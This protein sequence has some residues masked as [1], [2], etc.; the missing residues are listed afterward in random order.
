MGLNHPP[1]SCKHRSSYHNEGPG[2]SRP[3]AGPR[4]IILSWMSNCVGIMYE[5]DG[6]ISLWAEPEWSWRDGLGMVLVLERRSLP[7]ERSHNKTGNFFLWQGDVFHVICINMPL[8]RLVYC[9]C[10]FC[11]SCE[12][13][14]TELVFSLIPLEEPGE[15]GSPHGR[16]H[17]ERFQHQGHSSYCPLNPWRKIQGQRAFSYLWKRVG[18]KLTWQ[19][20]LKWWL[21]LEMLSRDDLM[22]LLFMRHWW[23]SV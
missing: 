4:W 16:N 5:V 1:F 7:K 19:K 13:Q 21:C 6:E 2:L 15:S 3:S 20:P 18:L 14:R 9:S 23:C 8:K 17:S 11:S 22:L 10:I 12:L